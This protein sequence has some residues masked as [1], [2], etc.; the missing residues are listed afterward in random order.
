MAANRKVE[1]TLKSKLSRRD[2]I[3]TLNTLD[4]SQ[5]EQK[6]IRKWK[7]K[8]KFGSHLKEISIRAFS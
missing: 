3:V 4:A 2:Y 1:Q 6:T 7:N 5:E 8:Q